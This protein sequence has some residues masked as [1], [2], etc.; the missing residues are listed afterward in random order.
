MKRNKIIYATIHFEI[1]T[2]HNYHE[3]KIQLKSKNFISAVDE[4]NAL[5]YGY[6]M[7]SGLAASIQTITSNHPKGEV[8]SIENL[9]PKGEF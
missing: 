2:S 6:K 4:A 9:K 8:C 1:N 5:I 7:G 3:F